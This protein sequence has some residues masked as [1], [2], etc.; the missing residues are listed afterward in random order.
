MPARLTE[1]TVRA[2]VP[3]EV[4]V[5]VSVDLVSTVTLPKARVLALSV[6][7]GVDSTNPIPLRLTVAALPVD[8][9]LEMVMVPLASPATV[10]SK[11][12]SR[13]NVCPGFSVAGSVTFDTEN[14][15]PVTVTEMIETGELP[16]EAST[17]RRVVVLLKVELPKA[18]LVEL[19]VRRARDSV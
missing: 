16:V 2:P 9:L 14:A 18:R 7:C 6:N 10:G 1:L 3:D 5:R 13:F 19:T 15:V 17:S 8:E 4:S 12:T 11:L